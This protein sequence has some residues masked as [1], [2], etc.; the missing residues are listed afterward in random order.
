MPGALLVSKTITGA[1]AGR[2]GPVTIGVTCGTTPLPAFTIPAGTG[3]ST[4]SQLYDGIPAGSTC[5]LTET[6]D[7]ATSTISVTVTGSNQTVTVPAATVVSVAVTDTY[8][9]A[10]GSLTVTKTLAGAAAGQQG[11]VAILVLCGGPTNLFALLIPPAT[12][13]GRSRGAS[14]ASRPDPPARSSR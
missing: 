7:G 14:T 8:T 13:A 12:P 11:G 6:A 3:A 5:T 4:V 2:Q 10:P 1:A 9:D